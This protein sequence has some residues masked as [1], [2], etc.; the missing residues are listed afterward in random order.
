MTLPFTG[1]CVCGAVRYEC[2]A[3]PIMMLNCHCRDCQR[4]SGGPYAPVVIIPANAFRLT[5]GRLQYHFTQKLRGGLHKRGFC[6]EC[7]SR[8]TGA[9]SDG[10]SEIIGV[11]ASSLDDSSWFKP[12]MDIFVSDVQAWHRMDPDLAKHT[13]YPPRK[14]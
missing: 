10:P 9:E 2:A 8:I 11:L 3:E 4:V 14:S 7:G 12:T 13:E 5:Q 1:G 6:P